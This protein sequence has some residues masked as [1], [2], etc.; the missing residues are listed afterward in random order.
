MSEKMSQMMPKDDKEQSDDAAYFTRHSKAEYNTYR[1]IRSSENPQ[2]GIDPENQISPDLSEE[3]VVLAEQKAEEFLSQFDPQKDILFFASSNEARALETANIYRK[4][5]IEKGFKIMKPQKAGLDFAQ[6]IGEGYIRVVRNLSLNNKNLLLQSLFNSDYQNQ[7][8]NWDAL[9]PETRKK[10]DE[11]RALVREHDYGSFGPNFF[12]HSEKAQEIFPE[13]KSAK[14]LFDGQFKR[15][16]KL[17]EFGLQ[18]AREA[19]LEK[20]VKILAFGHENYMAYALEKYFQDHEIKN[21]ETVSIEVKDSAVNLTRRG[22]LKT[23]DPNE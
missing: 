18:K 3:G 4:K 5:A 21:C 14:D 23:L 15:L 20:K 19:G 10:C 11:V 8:V 12:H 17:A 1:K 22:V 16:L 6:Q 9:D 2:A 13:I 7:S